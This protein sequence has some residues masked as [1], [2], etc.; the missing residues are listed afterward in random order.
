M[1]GSPEAEDAAKRHARI[2]EVFRDRFGG[3]PRRYVDCE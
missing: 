2:L 1:I 3:E